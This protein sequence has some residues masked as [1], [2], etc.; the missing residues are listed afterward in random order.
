M[1]I[2]FTSDVTAKAVNYTDC[3]SQAAKIIG[4]DI[5]P[6]DEQPACNMKRGTVE[7]GILTFVPSEY[8]T[9]AHVKA[10]AVIDGF[11]IPLPI[12]TD[13][14]QGYGLK[15]PLQKGVN[16]QFV[17]K[18]EIQAEFPTGKL[19]IKGEIIDPEEKLVVCFQFPIVIS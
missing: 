8:I 4:L 3:G 14:C 18:Q 10:Y 9:S 19:S 16:A 5:T 11:N 2:V 17:I 12:S 7:S 15:C 13:A 6:C 1:F